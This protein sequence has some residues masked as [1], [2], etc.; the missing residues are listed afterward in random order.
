MWQNGLILDRKRNGI[1]LHKG[2]GVPPTPNLQSKLTKQ[3]TEA[4][5]PNLPCV[6]C[7]T[8]GVYGIY[9]EHIDEHLKELG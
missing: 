1:E 3:R 2:P 6:C 4:H 7:G 5:K 9:I 8:T